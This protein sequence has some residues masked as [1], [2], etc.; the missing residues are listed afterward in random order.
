MVVCIK[1]HAYLAHAGDLI[2]GETETSTPGGRAVL[3]TVPA[4]LM[5]LLV[6]ARGGGGG[7]G[8]VRGSQDDVGGGSI[9]VVG[10]AVAGGVD[11]AV[12]V[13]GQVGGRCVVAAAA[14]GGTR[15]CRTGDPWQRLQ[16]TPG[17][18]VVDHHHLILAVDHHLDYCSRVAGGT[19]NLTSRRALH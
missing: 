18:F 14:G 2:L 9:V 12:V 1:A 11:E 3:G 8:V 7:G 19:Q 15:G 16:G 4:G 17:G 10:A 13:G 6:R 5:M